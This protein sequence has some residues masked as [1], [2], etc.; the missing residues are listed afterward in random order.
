MVGAVDRG[1]TPSRHRPRPE[2]PPRLW[3][4]AGGAVVAALSLVFQHELWPHRPDV[5]GWSAA[6][7]AV[8]LVALL[9]WGG[10]LALAA[11]VQWA[12]GYAG[13]RWVGLLLQLVLFGVKATGMLLLSLLVMV[14]L[15]VV[16]LLLL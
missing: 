10:H 16:L 15:V 11:L 13:P 9:A 12:G 7:L 6:L 1:G 3:L 8:M 5:A 14:L 2:V 4:V